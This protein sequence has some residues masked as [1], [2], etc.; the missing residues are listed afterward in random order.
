MEFAKQLGLEL[1]I[2][3]F[4]SHIVVKYNEEIVLDPFNEGKL[5]SAD[6]LQNILDRNYNGQVEFVPE[7]LNEISNKIILTRMMRNLKNSYAQSYDYNKSKQCIDM[8]LALEP[9]SP[10][11]IRD[12]GIV[13]ERLSNYDV[14][15]KYLNRYLKINPNGEDVDF[16]LQLIKSIRTKISQ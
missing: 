14:A 11:E 3:G 1:K 12:K 8:I 5:L 10:E 16:I 4:L 13:E 15:L 9:D 2:V 7:F 6:D